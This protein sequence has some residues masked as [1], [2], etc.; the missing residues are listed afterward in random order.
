MDDADTRR[1]LVLCNPHSG[2]A[3][4]GLEAALDVLRHAGLTLQVS[5]PE[6]AEA[7]SVAI[8]D[9]AETSDLVIVAG[10]DGTL[11]CAIPGLLATGKPLGILPT[12]TA[13]DLARSLEIPT[14]LR[15]A[16]EII[17][18]GATRR[19]DI[20]HC[21]DEP[22]F[23]VAT[24][25]LGAEVPKFHLG[26]RKKLL[27][28]AGYPLSLWD[29][30]RRHRPFRATIRADET[31]YVA[32]CV[33]IA[34]GNGRFHGGGLLVDER[35]AIT[36]GTLT[37]YFVEPIRLLSWVLFL[38][39][40]LRGRLRHTRE[41][42]VVRGSS[43]EIATQRPRHV[44]LDGELVAQTPARFT[45]S[46]GALEVFASAPALNPAEDSTVGTVT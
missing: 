5:E 32:R 39:A 38:P 37:L 44:N 29:A 33:Q 18:H 12:G 15:A 34:V 9:H 10:G 3:E 46:P 23:N 27:G 26:L 8:E 20:A 6:S 13:N 2:T 42:T 41:A 24:I 22:Y 45:I 21:N 30:Y 7:T 40:L 19:V 1:A 31:A 14:D 35:A 25:G 11:R 36:D 43:I 4:N 28:L 16:A 17:A